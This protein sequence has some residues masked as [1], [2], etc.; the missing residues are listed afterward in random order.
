MTDLVGYIRSFLD[1]DT[2]AF[3]PPQVAAPPCPPEAKSPPSPSSDDMLPLLLRLPVCH[4]A[5]P[6]SPCPPPV[7]APQPPGNLIPPRTLIGNAAYAWQA[8]SPLTPPQVTAMLDLFTPTLQ[9]LVPPPG[10]GTPSTYVLAADGT[11]VEQSGTI[12]VGTTAIAGGTSGSVI[13][14]ND[15]TVGQMG[16]ATAAQIQN[17][18]AGLLLDTDQSWAAAIP[19]AI[20]LT[21]TIDLDMSAGINFEEP[22]AA[23]GDITFTF[24]N[25]KPGQSGMIAVQAGSFT[26]SFSG[27]WV[28]PLGGVPAANSSGW[29][30][31]SYFVL[32]GGSVAVNKML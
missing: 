17:N 23:T 30:I 32:S 19:V 26:V 24:S 31:Y 5:P 1:E 2:T 4:P 21:G 11:W 3:T 27:N 29:T 7:C 22:A 28:P 20:G 15:G 25:A 9:G 10:S 16:V 18:T 8:A 12:T 13:T 14:N 6:L